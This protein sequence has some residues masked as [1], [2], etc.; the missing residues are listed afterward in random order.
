MERLSFL[1]ILQNDFIDKIGD[2]IP[3]PENNAAFMA[4]A[5][6]MTVGTAIPV[7]Y[8]VIPVSIRR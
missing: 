5:K 6:H 3:F 1:I 2:R 4:D 7:N 8:K